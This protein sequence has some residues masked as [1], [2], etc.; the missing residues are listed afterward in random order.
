MQLTRADVRAGHEH[1]SRLLVAAPS[2]RA[3]EAA[4][5]RQGK[6]QG[7]SIHF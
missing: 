7:M 2:F 4:L 5:L 6:R 3:G 1:R